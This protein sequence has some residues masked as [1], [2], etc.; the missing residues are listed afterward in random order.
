MNFLV[1]EDYAFIAWIIAIQLH[2]R[3]ICHLSAE[4]KRYWLT[5]EVM[6]KHE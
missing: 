3:L 6:I 4:N 1:I 5:A 2:S